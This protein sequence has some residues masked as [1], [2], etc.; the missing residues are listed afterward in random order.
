MAVTMIAPPNN[1]RGVELGLR[2]ALLLGTPQP[3]VAAT[4]VVPPAQGWQPPPRT[5]Q[6]RAGSY[7]RVCWG[8]P[9]V[10]SEDLAPV[11]QGAGRLHPD[12]TRR[13]AH[14][15]VEPVLE[16]WALASP[17]SMSRRARS[18]LHIHGI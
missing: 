18:S 12:R 15:A 7:Q 4:P 2:L 1:E 9:E 16:L 14:R 10:E 6:P 8:L 11:P 17:R 13:R 5:P 3:R